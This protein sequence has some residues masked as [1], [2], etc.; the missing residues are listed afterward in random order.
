MNA[1]QKYFKISEKELFSSI[2]SG[3]ELACMNGPLVGEEMMGGCF[4][5][6]EVE[7][8]DKNSVDFL[9]NLKNGVL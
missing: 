7:V 8:I 3:F 9:C 4:V 1:L 6:D 2:S 5:I